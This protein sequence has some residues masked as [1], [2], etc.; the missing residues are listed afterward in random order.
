[1]K[2]ADCVSWQTTA[3]LIAAGELSNYCS[4]LVVASN[5]TTVDR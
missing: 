2:Y 5:G 4:V 1:M 3:S